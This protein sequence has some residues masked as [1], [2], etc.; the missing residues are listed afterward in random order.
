MWF[1][2]CFDLNQKGKLEVDYFNS[3]NNFIKHAAAICHIQKSSQ[4]YVRYFNCVGCQ[5][6]ENHQIQEVHLN[7]K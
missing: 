5:S 2:I 1:S 6:P 7:F 3:T 4:G